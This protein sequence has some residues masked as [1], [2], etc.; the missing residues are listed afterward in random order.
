M[1]SKAEV[2]N[3]QK[4]KAFKEYK[5]SNNSNSLTRGDIIIAPILE[6]ARVPKRQK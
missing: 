1:D 4:M 2:R 5:T 3:T 6:K